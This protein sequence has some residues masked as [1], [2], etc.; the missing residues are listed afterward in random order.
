M[1]GLEAKEHEA[2]GYGVIV[3][4]FAGIVLYIGLEPAEFV[5]HALRAGE[6]K[7]QHPVLQAF[8]HE[9]LE[10]AFPGPDGGHEA[11][12]LL[13]EELGPK[14][15]RYHKDQEHPKQI[16]RQRHKIDRCRNELKERNHQPRNPLGKEFRHHADVFLQ[17]VH[18]VSGE[19]F[20]PS[21]PPALQHVAEEVL[22]QDVLGFHLAVTVPP[23]RE[24]DGGNLERQD[25]KEKADG[26][27]DGHAA[28]PGGDIHQELAGGHKAQ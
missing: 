3:Q 21:V 23:G 8:L 26:T 25:A 24:D 18:G 12:K 17:P 11:P 19:E 9:L 6:G 14:D 4:A 22:P 15:G 10:F 5:Q 27:S 1:A 2:P 28:V 20:L 7:Y 13:E 16:G